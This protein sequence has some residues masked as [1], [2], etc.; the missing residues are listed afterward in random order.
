MATTRGIAIHHT[1]QQQSVLV[2]LCTFYSHS[3]ILVKEKINIYVVYVYT[4]NRTMH[5]TFRIHESNK[6]FGKKNTKNED[7]LKK[8][9]GKYLGKKRSAPLVAVA[10]SSPCCCR[11]SR[12]RSQLA[13]E[14]GCRCSWPPLLGQNDGERRR[15]QVA[16]QQEE[17]VSLRDWRQKKIL[18]RHHDHQ[19]AAARKGQER[20]EPKKVTTGTSAPSCERPHK[21]TPRPCRGE[22]IRVIPWCA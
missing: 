4:K 12:S 19:S 17:Q 6:I 9:G 22:P 15:V 18:G 13:R 14:E 21:Y 11:W 7:L 5:E 1:Q 10:W 8:V 20:C 2:Y 3:R 16:T